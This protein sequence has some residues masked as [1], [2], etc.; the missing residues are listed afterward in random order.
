MIKYLYGRISASLWLPQKGPSRP[1][2]CSGVFL[3][4]SRGLFVYE[5]QPASDVLLAAIQKLNPQVAFTMATETTQ[6]VFSTLRPG[7][8]ELRLSN[9]SQ[10]QVVESMADIASATHK[11]KKF[12]YACLVRREKVLLVWHDD[13]QMILG[14]ANDIEGKL[15]ALV[16]TFLA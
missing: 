7:Q 2:D 3:R 12:Q 15:L 6:V 10:L 8:T 14:H 5:P 4:K 16:S 13:L 9:G 1:G 11:V